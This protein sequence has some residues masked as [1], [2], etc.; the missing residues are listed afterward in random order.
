[1]SN[2]S[3]RARLALGKN[4]ILCALL[5]MA[6]AAHGS[7]GFSYSSGGSGV[8]CTGI[9][10]GYVLTAED[11]SCVF[12]EGGG[13]TGDV[14]GPSSS[15]NSEIALFNGITGKLLK[16]LTGTGLV[17][18]TSGVASVATLVNADVSAS[19]AIART[20]LADGTASAVVINDSG[21]VM[22]SEAALSPVR[23]GTGVANNAAATTTRSGN[24]ALTI[25]TT[26][27]T[28]VTVPTSGTLSILGANT[29]TAAQAYGGF[30][31]T[32]TGT[33]TPSA[34][35]TKD[36]GATATQY[37]SVYAGTGV[38]IGAGGSPDTSA[39][40]Q[41]V[42]TSKYSKP[43]P[44]MTT[45][46]KNALTGTESACVWD[47][48]IKAAQCYNGTTWTGPN[49]FVGAKFSGTNGQALSTSWADVNCI[50][51][52]W[53][54]NS[55]VT[56]PTTAWRFTVATGKSGRYQVSFQT[57]ISFSADAADDKVLAS[58][59]ING[60]YS[61]PLGIAFASAAN[62]P[63]LASLGGSM[64]YALVAT[65]Y[66]E[67]KAIRVGAAGAIFDDVGIDD[68]TSISIRKID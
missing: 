67:V 23:G 40:L 46:Q 55:Q 1:M 63:G 56:N 7:G 20:K 12:A 42:S 15:V 2:Y 47:S 66:I 38:Y 45:T 17:K 32:G 68:N 37:R 39:G 19:A 48:T 18:A 21:G 3:F 4:M 28:G 24:H 14:V 57:R 62:V 51:S 25:T 34:D 44:S 26:G 6:S 52:R 35:N 50:T 22:G 36:V 27:T 41:V 61:G 43:F 13:G 10:N 54:T 5:L 16:S 31:L 64:D 59:W 60:T 30:D 53:D 11:N 33:V 29:F 58:V 49:G 8:D 65:D 9:T